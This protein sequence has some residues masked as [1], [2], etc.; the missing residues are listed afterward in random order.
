MHWSTLVAIPTLVLSPFLA[1]TGQRRAEEQA[2][3]QFEEVLS[4]A[5][6]AWKNERYG[7]CVK[8]LQQALQLATKKRRAHII[9]SLPSAPEGWTKV[10]QKEEDDLNT[11]PFAAQIMAAAGNVIT[12]QYRQDGGRGN[13]TFTVTTD[14]PMI[15]MFGMMLQNP[16]MLKQQGGELIEYDQTQAILKNQDGNLNLQMILGADTLLEVKANGLE[17]D[18]LFAL[19]S[20]SNLDKLTAALTH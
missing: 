17:E 8:S 20:Q 12:Q 9:A 18:G 16:A 13:A 7:T 6:E 11:N 15:Q 19:A 5:S 14:S 4:Q 3:P 2:P 10:P 1:P